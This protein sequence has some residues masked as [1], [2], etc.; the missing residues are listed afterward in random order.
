MEYG[1]RVKFLNWTQRI[2]YLDVDESH[3]SH[4]QQILWHYVCWHYRLLGRYLCIEK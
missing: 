1:E 4:V 2:P 3:V